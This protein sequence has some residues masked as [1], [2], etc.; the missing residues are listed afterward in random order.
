MAAP[1]RKIGLPARVIREIRGPLKAG[2][3]HS[4]HRWT[5]K[6]PGKAHEAGADLRLRIEVIQRRVGYDDVERAV[7]EG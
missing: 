6:P 7:A 2:Q 4:E 3:P 5:E 1:E